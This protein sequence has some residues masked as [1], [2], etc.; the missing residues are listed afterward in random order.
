MLRVDLHPEDA[1][2]RALGYGLLV[3]ALWAWLEIQTQ[4]TRGA[5]GGALAGFFSPVESVRE[6]PELPPRITEQVRQRVEGHMDRAAERR[7]RLA[8]GR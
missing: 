7:D 2:T 4:G 5:F 6:E 1:M 3:L 8:G